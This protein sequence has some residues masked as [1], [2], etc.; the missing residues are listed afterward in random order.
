MVP[1]PAEWGSGPH[2]EE[3]SR[4]VMD[5]SLAVLRDGGT[6]EARLRAR[7]HSAY[8]PGGGAEVSS[9]GRCAALFK[10]STTAQLHTVLEGASRRRDAAQRVA[11]GSGGGEGGGGNASSAAAPPSFVTKFVSFTITD[12]TYGDM[13]NDVWAGVHR[14]GLESTFFYVAL[15]RP[16][17]MAAC[18][19]HMPVVLFSEPLVLPGAKAGGLPARP[20]TFSSTKDRVYE[21]KYGLALALA[22]ERTN[23]LFFEMDCWMLS[24][25]LR[26]VAHHPIQVRTQNASFYGSTKCPLWQN[27]GGRS[28][29]FGFYFAVILCFSE[30]RFECGRSHAGYQ[31]ERKCGLGHLESLVCC[32]HCACSLVPPP[33]LSRH[34]A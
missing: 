2:A 8:G 9:A 13:L 4:F 15:D 14:L 23:F 1:T 29:P 31:R 12:A 34:E 30:R 28:A 32:E 6:G 27:G 21:A 5:M 7:R 3:V 22:R 17:A 10:P 20:A 18:H 11:A 26:A 33:F 24:H 25:P 16:T 19:H